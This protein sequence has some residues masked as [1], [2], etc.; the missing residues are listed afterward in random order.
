MI[1]LASQTRTNPNAQPSVL[2]QAELNKKADTVI[3]LAV[4]YWLTINPN[5]STGDANREVARYVLK[6]VSVGA[7]ARL[8]ILDLGELCQPLWAFP[9]VGKVAD[10]TTFFH[11]KETKWSAR[12][13][14]VC[15]EL[16]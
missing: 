9:V 11:T 6:R 5:V 1:Q 14:L 13:W 12:E 10:A 7:A 3:D 15:N 16:Y 4:G 2:T 8:A